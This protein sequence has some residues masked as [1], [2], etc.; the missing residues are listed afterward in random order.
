MLKPDYKKV[1][2]FQDLIDVLKDFD[3]KAQVRQSA[4]VCS[5]D[6]DSLL[7]GD[8]CI[9]DA[10]LS[11]DFNLSDLIFKDWFTMTNFELAIET[12]FENKKPFEEQDLYLDLTQFFGNK[13]EINPDDLYQDFD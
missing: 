8:G 1:Y 6:Y 3:P 10:D 5:H 4:G 11:D 7:I 12:F 13:E 2:T 9:D